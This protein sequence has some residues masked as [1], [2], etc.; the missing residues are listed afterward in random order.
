MSFCSI[1]TSE[2]GP[3]EYRPLGRNNADVLVCRSCDE[4]PPRE[5]NGPRIYDPPALPKMFHDKVDRAHKRIAN[6]RDYNPH[7]AYL[8]H[9]NER[10]PNTILIRVSVH[11]EDGSPRD[12]REAC[13]TFA[14]EPWAATTRYLGSQGD[15]HLFERPDPE[16]ARK[17]RQTDHRVIEAL[18]A[19]A[20]RSA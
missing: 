18:A 6:G 19:L 14:H 3:F 17:S 5:I 1:C 8:V 4:E 7:R 10:T 11:N 13:A 12:M 9:V 2:I 16:F 15:Y 20:K